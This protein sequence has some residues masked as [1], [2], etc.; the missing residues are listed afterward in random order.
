[1][2]KRKDGSVSQRGLWD[3]IR[4]N[5]GS[6]KK[7]TK[8][9]LQQEKKIKM[10]KAQKGDTLKLGNYN[11][12]TSGYSAG[13]KVFPYTAPNPRTTVSKK[14]TP[15][16]RTGNMGR[17]D[18]EKLMKWESKKSPKNKLGGKTLKKK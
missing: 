9:M 2:I 10:K 11:I 14:S 15:A 13:K 12:D 18:L 5:K 7:P 16:T 1:M 6:G 17:V 8:Q 4:A 3:N